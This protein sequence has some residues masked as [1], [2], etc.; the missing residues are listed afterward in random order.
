MVGE[1]LK[2][3][4]GISVASN[5]NS[6]IDYYI[7]FAVEKLFQKPFMILLPPINWL[8]IN[9]SYKRRFCSSSTNVGEGSNNN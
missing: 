6:G 4:C 5:N 3:Y 9:G 2:D 1:L 7:C 8:A